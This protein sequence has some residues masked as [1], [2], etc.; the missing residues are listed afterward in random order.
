[1][2]GY[3]RLVKQ[4]AAIGEVFRPYNLQG[5]APDVTPPLSAHGLVER[6]TLVTHAP[7]PIT[8]LAQLSID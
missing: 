7:L 8:E 6:P 5:H 2:T 4:Q 3:L 1:M